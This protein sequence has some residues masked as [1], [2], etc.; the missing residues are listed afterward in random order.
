[1]TGMS[2]SCHLQVISA[3]GIRERGFPVEVIGDGELGLARAL[4]LRAHRDP[5]GRG[6]D[7]QK[8]R[9]IAW[10]TVAV[11]DTSSPNAS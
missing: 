7:S 10:T 1:M 11:S 2:S 5:L 9:E 4:G 3:L 6:T 8:L